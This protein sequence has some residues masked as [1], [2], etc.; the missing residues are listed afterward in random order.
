MVGAIITDESQI[1][2]FNLIL[3]DRGLEQI[4][5]KTSE[6]K[7]HTGEPVEPVD[8][9]FSMH[10]ILKDSLSAVFGA[11]PALRVQAQEV[12][13][14][15][16]AY[17]KLLEHWFPSI[18]ENNL[19]PGKNAAITTGLFTLNRIVALVGNRSTGAKST[20]RASGDGQDNFAHQEQ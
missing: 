10:Q 15:A 4:E 8:A 13:M 20:S 12:D 11:M 17:G 14:L 19:T 7:V 9:S 5:G 1:L 18:D 16:D 2:E 6:S 3:A